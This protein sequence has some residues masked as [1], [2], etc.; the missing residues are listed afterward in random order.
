MT[1]TDHFFDPTLR[2]V[3]RSGVWIALALLVVI[4]GCK[5]ADGEQQADTSPP[6]SDSAPPS[7]VM[8]AEDADHFWVFADSKDELGAGGEFHVY[9]DAVTYP[10]ALAS[11][12]KFALGA[13]GA[14]PVH[15]HNKTEEI[16]YFLAG[17]GTATV[18][19]DGSPQDIEVGVGSVLYTPPGSWHAITNTGEQPLALVFAAIPNEKKGL[20]SFFRRIGI[21]PG[22]EP[23]ALSPEEF[24]RIAAEHDLI[25]RPPET[26][27]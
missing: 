13:G 8:Q 3:S 27:Q 22:E 20:L 1:R 4:S 7:V 6:A 17:Q 24:A 23:A 21:K 9:V 25:L 5:Q 11:F 2:A 14:L 10:D 18:Y 12:A 19:M 16:A 15:R 26:E